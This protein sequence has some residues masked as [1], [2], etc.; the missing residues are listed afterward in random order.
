MAMSRAAAKPPQHRPSAS[1]KCRICTGFLGLELD[2]DFE[3]RLCSSC[4]GRPEARRLG[5]ELVTSAAGTSISATSAPLPARDFTVAERSMINKL[6]GY[7]PA[8]QL[9]DLLNER[10]RGDLGPDA[11]PYGLDQLREVIGDMALAAPALVTNGWGA[12]RKLIAQARR[13]GV[14]ARI[15]EQV[16]NDFA[17]VYSLS[18]K[19]VLHLRDAL[20]DSGE[21]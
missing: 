13:S 21:A 6:H 10:L 9:L 16:I 12:Q 4:V 17:V 19:Q 20:L 18:A 1:T 3:N 14:L 2:D 5:L 8:Q 15:D 7:M 11:A